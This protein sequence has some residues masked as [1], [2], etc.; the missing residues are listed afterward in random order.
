MTAGVA[1]PAALTPAGVS[2][3]SVGWV[4]QKN[5]LCCGVLH[6]VADERTEDKMQ[7]WEQEC[8]L[9]DEVLGSKRGTKIL[10]NRLDHQLLKPFLL[11]RSLYVLGK[12]AD[13]S[14]S[15]VEPRWGS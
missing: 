4:A 8:E 5:T 15:K 12:V 14:E 1:A 10:G 7:R 6:V 2:S 9:W 11:Y 13:S 3:Q